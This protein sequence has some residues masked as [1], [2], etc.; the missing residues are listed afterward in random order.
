[1]LFRKSDSTSKTLRREV[2]F[3]REKFKNFSD[4][5][6]RSADGRIFHA[7]KCVLIARS[8]FFK[9]AFSENWIPVRLQLLKSYIKQFTPEEYAELD[10]VGRAKV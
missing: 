8:P 7:H 3:I 5:K 1:M 2:S 10:P 9:A 6:V 4:I